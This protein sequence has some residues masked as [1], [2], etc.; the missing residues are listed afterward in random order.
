[1]TAYKT[2]PV[3]IKCHSSREG[4]VIKERREGGRESGDKLHEEK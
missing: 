3:L 1:M 2:K 4:Y